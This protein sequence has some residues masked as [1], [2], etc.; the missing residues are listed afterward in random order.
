[1]QSAR[2]GGDGPTV[3]FMAPSRRQA[4]SNLKFEC[5]LD[6]ALGRD[7]S[8]NSPRELSEIPVVGG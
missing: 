1:M 6:G 3:I 5:V 7:P 2:V 4:R 8:R